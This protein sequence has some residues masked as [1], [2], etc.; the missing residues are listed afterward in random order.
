[1]AETAEGHV[2]MTLDAGISAVPTRVASFSETPG[3][4]LAEGLLVLELKYAGVFPHIFKDMVDEFG[5][6]PHPAS[7]YRLAVHALNLA[8]PHVSAARG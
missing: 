7:K 8:A 4:S 3:K 5:L 1:M 2:R 6:R